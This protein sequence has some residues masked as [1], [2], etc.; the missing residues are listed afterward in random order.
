MVLWVWNTLYW[1]QNKKTVFPYFRWTRLKIICFLYPPSTPVFY[2]STDQY[3]STVFW[4]FLFVFVFQVVEQHQL[5]GFHIPA[6]TSELELMYCTPSKSKKG[7]S[8]KEIKKESERLILSY[9]T[10][11]VPLTVKVKSYFPRNGYVCLGYRHIIF[12]TVTCVLQ[13]V[14]ILVWTHGFVLSAAITLDCALFK[15][16][17]KHTNARNRR[18]GTVTLT[19]QTCRQG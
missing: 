12:S 17:P 15:E 2:M 13:W 18:D 19:K 8:K 16:N 11:L 9:S 6:V 14:Q 5:N 3:S 7:K 1:W 10:S 4:F